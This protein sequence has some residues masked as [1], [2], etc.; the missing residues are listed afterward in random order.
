ML[1]HVKK[2]V[3]CVVML[4]GVVVVYVDRVGNAVQHIPVKE[5]HNQ[6][7][8]LCVVVV[9]VVMVSVGVAGVGVASVGMA[10]LKWIMV[11]GRR[12]MKLMKLQKMTSQKNFPIFKL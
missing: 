6:L 8:M 11:M 5:N 12:K 1:L 9:G 2:S 3:V 4:L 7:R 10:L